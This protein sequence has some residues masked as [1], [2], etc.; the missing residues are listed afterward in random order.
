MSLFREINFHHSN[1]SAFG[2]L[3]AVEPTPLIQLNFI[4][5]INPQTATT[6]ITDTGIADIN[7][8]RLR[9]QTGTNS[10]G[11]A[12]L[13]SVRIAKYRTGQG[14][15]ARFT[16]AFASPVANS[17]QRIGVSDLGVSGYFFGYNDTSF[18]ICHRLNNADTWIPQS[19]WNGDNLG[20]ALDPTLGNVYYIYYPY[21]GY[22]PICFFICP[23]DGNIIHVHT[24]KYPNTSTLVQLTNPSMVF[25][26][27]IENT[28]NTTNLTNYTASAAIFCCGK[29]NFGGARFV[30]KNQKAIVAGT[31][32][33][34]FTVRN[35]TTYNGLPNLS[36]IR[37]NFISTAYG[38]LGN[39]TFGYVTM[40]RNAT[41]GGVP[42]Y[43]PLSGTTADNGVTITNG[44]SCASVDIAG[45]TVTGGN[46][47]WNNTGAN[48]NNILMNLIDEDYFLYPGETMT[49]VGESTSN[50]NISVALNWTEDN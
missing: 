44:N 1:L 48:A 47:L 18:G 32:T 42:S 12:M 28:G 40:T 4:Y 36:V 30:T 43:T 15:I 38:N 21:L 24:I 7:T 25:Y 46:P 22:G 20:F 2:D 5:G 50:A 39:N 37:F 10:T 35:A 23:P 49:V 14:M 34:I 31:V 9:L 16:K 41:L 19:S 27:K 29:N 45:T 8:Q 33:N 11:S 3:M 26:D 17:I 6:S 13:R